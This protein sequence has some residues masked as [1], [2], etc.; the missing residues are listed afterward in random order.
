MLFYCNCGWP[1]I[2]IHD[3]PS[4]EIQPYK[5]ICYFEV[6]IYATENERTNVEDIIYSQSL[7]LTVSTFFYLQFFSV[8]NYAEFIPS[9]SYLLLLQCWI[10][11]CLSLLKYKFLLFFLSREVL[12]C[13][14]PFPDF[15]SKWTSHWCLWLKS[16]ANLFVLLLP[17]YNSFFLFGHFCLNNAF[18]FLS[19]FRFLRSHYNA[20]SQASM[21][22]NLYSS[23]WL[24]NVWTASFILCNNFLRWGDDFLCS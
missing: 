13:S 19:H 20:H 22:Y 4:F 17:I 3:A 1:R 14:S 7:R 16:F 18:R 12:C 9:F 6:N 11:F 5:P 23:V 8:R 24:I 21:R 2:R 10:C 15:L